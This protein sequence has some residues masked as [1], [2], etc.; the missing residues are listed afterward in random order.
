[1]SDAEPPAEEHE[2]VQVAI[3]AQGAADYLKELAAVLASADVPHDIVAP[4]DCE[5]GSCGPTLLLVTP[6]D[7]LPDARAA[8]EI[9]WNAELADDERA[10]AETVVDFDAE[11]TTCPACGTSFPT[12][13]TDRCPECGLNFGG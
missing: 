13:K 5:P 7:A 4:P 9:H 8:I 6:P 1:M 12:S 2:T 3:V 10:A 11:E